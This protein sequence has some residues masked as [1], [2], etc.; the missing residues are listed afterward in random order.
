MHCLNTPDVICA[1]ESGLNGVHPGKTPSVD[2]VRNSEVFPPNYRAY[3]NDRGTLGGGVF[4]LIH[5]DLVSSELPEQHV[6]LLGQK[7]S[8]MAKGTSS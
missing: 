5:K 2:A 8:Y 1:T 4:V 7:S 3:C 6:K